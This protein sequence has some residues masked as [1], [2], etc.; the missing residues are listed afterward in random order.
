MTALGMLLPACGPDREPRAQLDPICGEPGPFRAL[1][2][3]E[4]EAWF[5]IGS[6]VVR[7]DDRVYFV[8]GDA[9]PVSDE[10]FSNAV[11]TARNPRVVSVGPCGESPRLVVDAIASVWEDP[12]WPG[13]LVGSPEGSADLFVIDPDGVAAPRLLLPQPGVFGRS[14]FGVVAVVS[15]GPSTNTAH[16]VLQPYPASSD[17]APPPQIVLTE[18]AIDGHS[19]FQVL[20]REAFVGTL[21]GQLLAIDLADEATTVLAEEVIAFSVGD[22]GTSV[23]LLRPHATTESDATFAATILDRASGIE[24]S[25]GD[26]VVGPI[27]AHGFG[28]EVLL[29][30]DDDATRIV[31]VP[32]LDSHDTP[33]KHGLWHRVDGDIFIGMSDGRFI[34]YDVATGETR[35]LFPEYGQYVLEPDAMLVLDAPGFRDAGPLYRSPYRGAGPIRIARRATLWFT[36]LGDGRVVTPVDVDDEWVGDL[37]LVDPEN[38]DDE[39]RIDDDIFAANARLDAGAV[40]GD[41]VLA[42]AVVDGDRSGIWLAR[43]SA[44]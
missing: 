24:T 4:D 5:P 41:G 20:A 26:D 38:Q 7:I 37:V 42:Y 13:I 39:L 3:G 9:V 21:D 35:E 34:T 19:H 11:P 33:A 28:T 31:E 6:N 1:E 12:R 22:D 18:G 29:D 17:D 27:D 32:S 43:P 10:S 25:L 44:E 16:V 2:L 8:I 36:R 23:V 15:D 40:F 30:L 14:D